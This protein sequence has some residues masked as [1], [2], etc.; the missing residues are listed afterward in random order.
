[1]GF[2]ESYLAEMSTK[3]IFGVIPVN[4]LSFKGNKKV[5]SDIEEKFKKFPKKDLEK[6]SK[7]LEIIQKDLDKQN[8]ILKIKKQFVG[9]AITNAK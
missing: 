7:E 9:D 4:I 8:E 3:N 5:I 1:M 2:K 6:A